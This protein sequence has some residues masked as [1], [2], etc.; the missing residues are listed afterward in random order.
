A[1]CRWVDGDWPPGAEHLDRFL[2]P[3]R[4]LRV[5]ANLAGHCSPSLVTGCLRRG[6]CVLYTPLS[7]SWRTR[8]EAVQR[9]SVRRALAGPHPHDATTVTPWLRDAVAGGNRPPTAFTWGGKRHAR[10]DRASARR[11]RVRGSGATTTTAVVQRMRSV[12][13]YHRPLSI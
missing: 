3:I 12:R 2:P 1:G 6:I 13:H 11:H 5:L 4:V 8:A 10:R 7:G 9:I